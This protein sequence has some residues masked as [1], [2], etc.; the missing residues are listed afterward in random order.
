MRRPFLVIQADPDRRKSRLPGVLLPTLRSF[1]TLNQATFWESIREQESLNKPRERVLLAKRGDQ[2][3]MN[4]KSDH[5]ARG[6]A[7][8]ESGSSGG[9]DRSKK[10]TDG[11]ATICWGRFF[12]LDS[13]ALPRACTIRAPGTIQSTLD[14]WG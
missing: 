7:K 8:R 13:A 12:L 9:C 2:G 10:G 6:D 5:K 1:W 3:R 4:Y 14:R 11:A